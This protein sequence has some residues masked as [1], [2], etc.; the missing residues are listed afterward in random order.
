MQVVKVEKLTPFQVLVV[1]MARI[2]YVRRYTSTTFR[3]ETMLRMMLT[4]PR[5]MALV[6]AAGLRESEMS[7]T[8]QYDLFQQVRRNLAFRQVDYFVGPS[9]LH[10]LVK[11]PNESGK[12]S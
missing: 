6:D 10:L 9:E 4:H 12:K 5:V 8:E 3:M 7:P 2:A 1:V 11:A